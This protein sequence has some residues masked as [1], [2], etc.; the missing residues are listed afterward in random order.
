MNEQN[1]TAKERLRAARDA[2]RDGRYAEALSEYI[3]FHNHALEE[4]PSLRGVRRSFALGYWLELAAAY[5]PARAALKG[6]RDEKTKR[7]LEGAEDWELFNDALPSI[8]H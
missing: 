4:M 1:M 7:L 3:W 6:V 5:P 2:A 8:R